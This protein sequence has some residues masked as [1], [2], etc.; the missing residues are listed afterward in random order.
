MWQSRVETLDGGNVLRI[1]VL[2]EGIQLP[3]RDVLRHWQHDAGFREY[4]GSLLSEALFPAFF[5]ETPAVSRATLDQ[6]FEF[7]LVASSDLARM[8]PDPSAFESQWASRDVGGDVVTFSNLGGDAALV[9]PCPIAPPSAYGHIAA[10]VRKAPE[11]QRHAFWQAVGAALED[12]LDPRP[13]WL[14][15]SGLG[16][17]WLHA[18]LDSHP[19]YYQYAPYRDA[20]RNAG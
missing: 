20:L 4:F 5:W 11:A 17:A 13:M 16:V 15:T 18:R 10:F 14:S 12:R 3:Y 19:K 6:P 7:V 2:S 9:A 1:G 8:R